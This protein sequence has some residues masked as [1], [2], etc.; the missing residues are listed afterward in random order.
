MAEELQQQSPECRGED[1]CA[2]GSAS[3]SSTA[4]MGM[5]TPAATSRSSRCSSGPVS[6]ATA[7]A[8]SMSPACIARM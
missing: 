7:Q 1:E 6:S 2:Q 4:V 8:V 3:W 5:K